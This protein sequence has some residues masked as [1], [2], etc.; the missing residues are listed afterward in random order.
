MKHTMILNKSFAWSTLSNYISLS[1]MEIMQQSS[2][3]LIYV[4]VS[5]YA[6]LKPSWTVKIPELTPPTLNK[7][8]KRKAVSKTTCRSGGKH[9]KKDTEKPAVPM[10]TNNTRPV[11]RT[12]T[13]A[14]NRLNQYGIGGWRAKFN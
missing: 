1:D 3:I 8:R 6:V 11:R 13:L 12:R 2:I 10:S 4:G 7:P 5:K 14:E 9:L